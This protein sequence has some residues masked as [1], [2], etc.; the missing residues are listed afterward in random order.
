LNLGRMFSCGDASQ[1]GPTVPRK[2]AGS[3]H[4]PRIAELRA[5]RGSLTQSRPLS[6]FD[7]EPL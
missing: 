6:F 2:R 3:A 5:F 7:V 4:L 1:L